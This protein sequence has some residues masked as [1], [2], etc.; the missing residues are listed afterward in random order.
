VLNGYNPG[1]QCFQAG[2]A[3]MVMMKIWQYSQRT[4]LYQH[5]W[6]RIAVIQ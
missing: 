2:R 5:K 1:I 6:R 4:L 3:L